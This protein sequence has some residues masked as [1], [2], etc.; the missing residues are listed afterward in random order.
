LLAGIVRGAATDCVQRPL[1]S[2]RRFFVKLSRRL[3]LHE[4]QIMRSAC[5][6]ALAA[7][8]L[9]LSAQAQTSP[10]PAPASNLRAACKADGHKFCSSVQPGGGRIIECLNAHK[11]ELSAACQDALKNEKAAHEKAQ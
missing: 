11:T 9:T 1:L 3:A 2:G 4:V 5:L 10:A 8:V 6:L 7:A